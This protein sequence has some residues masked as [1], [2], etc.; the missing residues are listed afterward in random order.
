MKKKDGV[1]RLTRNFAVE[2]MIQA[3]KVRTAL[4]FLQRKM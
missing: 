1:E 3:N 2:S 4:N